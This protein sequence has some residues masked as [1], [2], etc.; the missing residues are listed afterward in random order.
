M[1]IAVVVVV[2]IACVGVIRGLLWLRIRQQQRKL[3]NELKVRFDRL[4]AA[5][6]TMRQ[7]QREAF[8]AKFIVPM[9]ARAAI[10]AREL[11]DEAGRRLSKAGQKLSQAG[12]RLSAANGHVSQDVLARLQ[13]GYEEASEYFRSALAGLSSAQ[14]DVTRCE[15]KERGA[16]ERFIQASQT[17]VHNAEFARRAYE[18][19]EADLAILSNVAKNQNFPALAQDWLRTKTVARLVGVEIEHNVAC[20]YRYQDEAV[21][22]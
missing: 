16:R 14:H 7:S 2:L 12:I 20:A 22:G 1:Q 21:K 18:A 8:T 5:L 4:N 17:F 11:R 15:A 19:L 3:Q 13:T 9:R 6:E 10:E